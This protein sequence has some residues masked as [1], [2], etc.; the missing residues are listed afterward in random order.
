MVQFNLK[1]FDTFQLEVG[2]KVITAVYSDKVRLL[3]AYLCVEANQLHSR[4]KLANLFWSEQSENKARTNLRNNL[5]HLRRLLQPF[6]L[7]KTLF[8]F[9]RQTLE[10]HYQT[11]LAQV[12]VL[13]F[14]TAISRAK[15]H[16]HNVVVACE[17]CCQQ[18]E[19]AV[20]LYRGDFLATLTAKDSPPFEV[21]RRQ[22]QEQLHQQMLWA[23]QQLADYFQRQANYE[24]AAHYAQRQLQLEIWR[25]VAH[26]QLMVALVGS[27]QKTAAL[28]QYDLCT[29][30]LAEELG[31][32]PAAET[33]RL[34]EQ[35]KAN[36]KSEQ[37]PHNLPRQSTPFVGRETDITYLQS[38][39]EKPENSL[40]TI[41]GQGGIGKT[42][43]A[44]TF[45]E[46]ILD[47]VGHPLAPIH[48]VFFINL[49]PLSHANQI[50]PTVAN[51]L[52]FPLSGQDGRSPQQQLLDYLRNKRMLLLFDNFEHVLD[53]VDLLM[54][55]LQSA[56]DV[57]ILVTSRERLRL[58]AEQVYLIE[59]LSIPDWEIVSLVSEMETNHASVQLF[60]QSAR[61][62]QPDFSPHSLEEFVHL[63]RICH[64]VAGMP[65]ALELAASW[66][67]VMPLSEIAAELQKG[68]DIL[69]TDMRD[70]PQ[71]HRSI[72][73][74]I[75]YSWRRLSKQE[76]AVFAK[77]SVF[78]GGF[79]LEA[80]QTITGTNLRQLSRLVSKSLLR[81]GGS[82][83]NGR[84]QIHEL[85]RQ[86]GAEKLI[87]SGG[88]TAV[89]NR[90]AAYYAHFLHQHEANLKSAR[91]QATLA[92]IETNSDNIHTSWYWA[93]KQRNIE[94]LSQAVESLCLF[95]QWRERYYAG[96]EACQTAVAEV[97]S[98]EVTTPKEN[99]LLAKLFRWQGFFNFRLG[100][101]ERADQQLQKSL[102]IL[103]SSLFADWDVR[104]A[105]AEA[106][107]IFGYL[108]SSTDRRQAPAMFRRS[109]ECYRLLDNQWEIA[110]TLTALGGALSN[111][112]KLNEAN[113]VL[114]EALIIHRQLE[115]ARGLS[116]T[117]D[118]LS[119]TARG[120]GDTAK[121]ERLAREAIDIWRNINDRRGVC[122]GF[123]SLG[124]H[125]MYQGKFEEAIAAHEES[126]NIAI[127]LGDRGQI[128]FSYANLALVTQD[129]GDYDQAQEYVDRGLQV[130]QE[131]E[132][133]F[134]K[135]HCLWNQSRLS[136]VQRNYKEAERW[137]LE[138]SK[139]NE[140]AGLPPVQCF[141]N[142]CLARA[143]Y[144]QGD[145]IRAKQ[146]FMAGLRDSI[147]LEDHSA[148]A[149]T[150]Y[151]MVSALADWGM[152]ERAIEIHA[153]ISRL[154]P[155]AKTAW[156][157][158]VVGR[159]VAEAA[160]TLPQDVV[161]SVE[162]R[163]RGLD[164]RE[165]AVL[166]LEELER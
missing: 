123:M 23:C 64:I 25:E 148:M 165:T 32:E 63:A 13:T 48:G 151:L 77:L 157:T 57:K 133:D 54:V 60:L 29:Q 11:D 108:T 127:D 1:L 17:S 94:Q 96:E 162:A 145:H 15:T 41:V 100:S 113:A 6:L 99:Y 164:L 144:Q 84:Y 131:I 46:Q 44:L 12:D 52:D 118:N 111:M 158:A 59:G 147:E 9:N 72:R 95:Y 14:L 87:E 67:D 91:Q 50:V 140:V 141:L 149:Y 135:T 101:L 20:A 117:L 139:A 109:L 27:G 58:R 98:T 161:L 136:L 22:W 7:N 88:E 122:A 110:N 55:I 43:L 78:R 19:E 137:A 125:L 93:V 51:V 155:Q 8:T 2:G 128:G 69:E 45:A 120:V 86:Y 70:M 73:T 166:L 102:T 152:V 160:A 130:A 26:R 4:P 82:R 112:G 103:N 92:E 115:N 97:S 28:Q 159:F 85:L 37:T 116:A 21:W 81:G 105:Q 30:I 132:S 154:I 153:L 18:L 106:W 80:A 114:E 61:R 34:Y 35:I 16:D 10:F 40:I 89:R 31:I 75:D 66:V 47:E 53:G 71:R 90:H 163:G 39:W 65:L 107:M 138:G 56:S 119:F 3:L 24:R 143:V 49:A 68:L 36:D 142:A 126:L 121:A 134:I 76:Q 79:T 146:I 129:K 124:F 83:G 74:A 5:V 42:R 156:F 62:R 38:L 150:V 104:A 33:Q